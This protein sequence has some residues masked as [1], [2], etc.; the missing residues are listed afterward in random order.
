MGSLVGLTGPRS[1]WLPGFSCVEAA[2]N[3]LANRSHEVPDHRNGGDPG[4]SAGSL[5]GCV[6]VQKTLGDVTAH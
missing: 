3:W 5:L 2:S 4:A 1:S 6:R